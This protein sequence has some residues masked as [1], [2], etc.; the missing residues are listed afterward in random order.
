[1][2]Y[3]P[4]PE[5]DLGISASSNKVKSPGV[6]LETRFARCGDGTHGNVPAK[7]AENLA[8]L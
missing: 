6:V 8:S 2:G 3:Y 4:E 7:N 5:N 1:M